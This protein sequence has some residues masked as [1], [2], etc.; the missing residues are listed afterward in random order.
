MLDGTSGHIDSFS[1]GAKIVPS[2]IVITQKIVK[3]VLCYYTK[4]D[5]VLHAAES[6]KRGVLLVPHPERWNFLNFTKM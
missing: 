3:L 4:S 6:P 5:A 1:L 2:F